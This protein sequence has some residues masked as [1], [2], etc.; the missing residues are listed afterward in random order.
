[1]SKTTAVVDL[2]KRPATIKHVNPRPEYHGEDVVLAIDVKLDGIH[3]EPDELNLLLG[4]KHAHAALFK[5]ANGKGKA[6][7]PMFRQLKRF[8]LVDKFENCTATI[9]L[10]LT[11]LEVTFEDAKLTKVKLTPLVGGQTLMECTVQAE[12]EDTSDVASLL[13]YLLSEGTAALLIGAKQ[14]PKGD[15]AQKDLDL[16]VTANKTADQA[17]GGTEDMPASTH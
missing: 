10:G 7:E 15:K 14:K 9:G 17:S 13:D 2:P 8:E 4:D 12:I 3:L 5:T 11:D 16:G 1:M 6:A